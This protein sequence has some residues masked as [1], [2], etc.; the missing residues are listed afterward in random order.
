MYTKLK[1][2]QITH[3]WIAE[4]NLKMA[5]INI[6][7]GEPL[8]DNLLVVGY[9]DVEKEELATSTNRVKRVTKDGVITAKGTFYPIEEAHELYL[10]FLIEANKED[11]LV[12]I[13]WEYAQKL[14]KHKIIADVVKDGN[15]ERGVTFD[16]TPDKKYNVMFS[17]Y[18]KDLSANIVLTTFARRNVCITLAIP[19]T[20][21]ADIAHSSFAL[22]DETMQKVKS[23]KEI[24]AENF[25]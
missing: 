11:T 17:G 20:V 23:V 2:S 10:S 21:R 4:A 24:F 12:A 1:K 8:S 25:K 22:Q 19:D 18:S 7:S 6:L 9:L 15:I 5:F 16:F 14:C 13:N 3:W